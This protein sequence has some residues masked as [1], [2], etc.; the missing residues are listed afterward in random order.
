MQNGSGGGG[1]NAMRQNWTTRT[2]AARKPLAL[3]GTSGRRT[4]GRTD[5]WFIRIKEGNK[6]LL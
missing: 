2:T 5:G 6:G 1:G 4:D 3:M